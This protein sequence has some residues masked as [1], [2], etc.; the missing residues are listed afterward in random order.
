MVNSL[1]SVVILNYN[2]FHLI[3]KCNA[4]VRNLKMKK[5]G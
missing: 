3:V 5:F 1:I 2:Y 4:S